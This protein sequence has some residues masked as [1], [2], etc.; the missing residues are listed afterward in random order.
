M[1]P[2]AK[3]PP[4]GAVYPAALAGRLL[5]QEQKLRRANL[6]SD[7][8]CSI[9][10]AECL[11]IHHEV[12]ADGRHLTNK[13]KA[14]SKIREPSTPQQLVGDPYPIHAHPNK[15]HVTAQIGC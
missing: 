12:D 5:R 11:G 13:G 10:V 4:G 2:K 3:R 6:L 7:L 9:E 1:Y 8:H 15:M 14:F